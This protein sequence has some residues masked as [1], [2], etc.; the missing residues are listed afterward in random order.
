M[1]RKKKRG[2]QNR[3][4][5]GM[6]NKEKMAEGGSAVKQMADKSILLVFG[7]FLAAMRG[8]ELLPVAAMLIGVVAAALG[9]YL[10]HP[11]E[12]VLVYCAFFLLC[13][14][15]PELCF[16]LPAVFYDC[17]AERFYWGAAGVLPFCLL[18][19]CGKAGEPWQA[20]LWVLVSV[21]ALLLA[22]RTGRNARL[23]GELIRLRDTSTE[24]NMALKEKNRNLLEKQDNEIYLAT[25][26]ERNRIAREIHDNVGHMLSRSILQMGALL[27][28]HREEPLHGQLSSVNDT[29]GQAMTSIR[30]SVHDL[31]DNSVDLRLAVGE[32][33][34]PMFQKYTVQLDYDMTKTAVPRAVK[35]CFLA[36][37]KEAMSNVIKHSDATRIEIT[38]R[39]QP[40]FYQLKIRD[41]G[42]GNRRKEKSEK[43]EGIGLLNMRNRVEALDGTFR[44][45]EENGFQIFISIKKKETEV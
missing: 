18:L 8:G 39:E 27:V 23:E 37:V 34:K 13:F 5:N 32:I 22:A 38:L 7:I 29:L 25:L 17:A 14:L 21:T 41:N 6:F 20:V 28:S 43:S 44:V 2:W 35:Y 1:S 4:N 15:L 26:K 30:E 10:T 40:V 16:F 33:L 12:K 42:T 3:E 9:L 45:T 36:A 19:Y 24:L 11:R 31:H